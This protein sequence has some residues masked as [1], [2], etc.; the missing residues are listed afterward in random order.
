MSLALPLNEEQ[1][2]CL[3]ELTNVAIG[4]A[5]E[6]LAK[7]LCRF[8]TLPIPLIRFVDT[9]ELLHSFRQIEQNIPSSLISQHC[10]VGELHCHALVVV[11]DDS[12]EELAGC[13]DVEMLQPCFGDH[14]VLL[15][16]LFTTISDT[17]FERLSEILEQPIHREALGVLGCHVQPASIDMQ[18]F[19]DTDK[20]VAIEIYYHTE[21]HPFNCH[22]ILLFPEDNV[23]SLAV[24]LD[25]LLD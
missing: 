11:S 16:N 8:I 17:C 19:I 2:D 25:K 13:V 24:S 21:D 20:A 1:R 18:K 4:A 12:I 3:Q 14:E 15:E 10:R 7:L 23:A 6:S 5:A 9:S 22:L